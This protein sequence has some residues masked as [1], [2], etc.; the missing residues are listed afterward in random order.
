MPIGNCGVINPRPQ[1]GVLY[2][3]F[4]DVEADPSL[5]TV[6]RGAD[7]M[8]RFDPDVVVAW[9]GGSPMDA[10]KVMRL[11]YEHPEMSLYDMAVR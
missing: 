6:R 3:V 1:H 4:T 5:A 7:A 8:K 11:M 2:E 9:G 10:A